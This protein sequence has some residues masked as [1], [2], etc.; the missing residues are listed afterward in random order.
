MVFVVGMY[1]NHRAQGN[2]LF[3]LVVDL[4]Q[5]HTTVLLSCPGFKINTAV[6]LHTVFFMKFLNALL[7]LIACVMVSRLPAQV[8]VSGT[9]VTAADA[10]IMSATVALFPQ[11]YP[12]RMV[13]YSISG[14]GGKFLITV[15]DTIDLSQYMLKIM[16]I[17]HKDTLVTRVVPYMGV[18]RLKDRTEQLQPVT[19]QA[20][21]PLVIKGDTLSYSVQQWKDDKDR[22]IEDVLRRIPGVEIDQRGFISHNGRYINH[23]YINGMD[24]LENRYT[25][26]SQGLPAGVIKDIEILQRHAHK[27][28]EKN[29][30]KPKGVSINLVT[31]QK[32]ILTGIADLQGADP[33]PTAGVE[34][35]TILI[36]PAAQLVASLKGTNL[37]AE[38]TLDNRTT[39]YGLLEKPEPEYT[40]V[41]HLDIQT[42]QNT[43]LPQRYWRDTHTGNATGDHISTLNKGQQVKVGYATDYD[44]VRLDNILTGTILLEDDV[45]LNKEV[46]E[47]VGIRRNHYLKSYVEHNKD[48]QFSRLDL[49]GHFLNHDQ[50][51]SQ[52]LN[53]EGYDSRMGKTGASVYG[54]YQWDRKTDLGLWNLDLSGQF[55]SHDAQLGVSPAVFD[56]LNTESPIATLQKIQSEEW[57]LAATS[58]LY[59]DVSRGSLELGLGLDYRNQVL[60]TDLS[61]DGTMVYGMFPFVNSQNYNFLKP[62]L[63]ATYIQR[64]G[65]TQLQLLS[66]L[67]PIVVA[68]RD[69]SMDNARVEGL[70][71]ETRVNLT[72]N[73]SSRWQYYTGGGI[74]NRFADLNSLVTGFVVTAYNRSRQQENQI[75]ESRRVNAHMGL[76]YKN[77]IKGLFW[78]TRIAYSSTNYALAQQLDFDQRG[79]RIDTFRELD[80]Q[81]YSLNMETSLSK[82]LGKSLN[83]KIKINHDDD[84]SEL[85]FNSEFTDFSTSTTQ[86]TLSGS[87]D[88]LDW[89][90]LLGDLRY[91]RATS[92]TGGS[93][94]NS[95]FY[96]SSLTFGQEWGNSLVTELIYNGQRNVFEENVNQNHL[97]DFK[98]IWK[99]ANKSVLNLQC[100]NLTNQ[101][102]YNSITTNTNITSVSSFPLLGR[103]FIL[104]YKLM[105]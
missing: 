92:R 6:C 46:R 40:Y 28:V 61:Q 98:A 103:Q 79:F 47:V 15:K 71:L 60:H 51:A 87:Y 42:A 82:T 81:G 102:N 38:H 44:Q 75:Q 63:N 31:R 11:L 35:T 10:P 96:S 86:A 45:I 17:A 57:I 83:L 64:W 19:I 55:K 22:S 50:Y 53:Q 9:L 18:L 76:H 74:T 101:K 14:S 36:R 41:D 34:A 37:G 29:T 26:A 73:P 7:F 24:L 27:Q 33:I 21:Q 66:T 1:Q 13:G 62:T 56:V 23:L 80:N 91:S 70:Y 48:T 52:L 89:F 99:L 25:I 65:K 3:W 5:Y 105:F 58:S 72:Y 30:N 85:F 90:Y 32:S 43:N 20:Q 4:R 69:N 78:N 95:H 100:N 94:F 84:H 77:V 49:Y 104:S 97:I 16:H 8:Q 2:L 68:S 12:D 88:T 39:T 59:L 93:S 67:Y 54:S